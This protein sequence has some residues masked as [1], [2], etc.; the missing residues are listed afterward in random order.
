MMIFLNRFSHILNA[1]TGCSTS[2]KAILKIIFGL[3]EPDCS[4]DIQGLSL[5]QYF[6]AMLDTTVSFGPSLSIVMVF[7]EK[8]ILDNGK[9]MVSGDDLSIIFS[10]PPAGRV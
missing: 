5:A 3:I 8:D 1:F 2:S 6:E 9:E 10:S 7:S 4:K